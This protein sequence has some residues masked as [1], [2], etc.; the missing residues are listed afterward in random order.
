[1]SAASSSP[2][3]HDREQRLR[4]LEPHTSF[5]VQ[6]PAGSGKTELLTL[7][8]LALLPTVAEPEQVLAITFTRK[9][10]AE[11]RA[12]I[13]AA[14]EAA[15]RLPAQTK[16]EQPEDEHQRIVRQLA[17]AA[18]AHANAHDWQLLE[19]PQRL[20]IQ[21]IDSLALS[22]ARQMPLLS[23]LGGQLSPVDDAE[24]LYALAAQRTLARLGS[25][26]DP[27]LAASLASMLELRDT[28]L[29]DCEA[30]IAGM[31][32]RREQWL[33][34]LPG[35][36]QRN[37]AW[38]EL[39]AELE[40]PFRRENEAV[41]AL[42]Q[43]RF[44]QSSQLLPELLELGRIACENGIEE[45]SVLQAV[46]TAEDL[47]ETAHCHALCDLLLTGTN[48]WRKKID[49]SIGF[50][51]TT[52]RAEGARLKELIQSL[53]EDHA[54]LALLCRAR[55]LPPPA[56]TDQEWSL[57]RSI[58]TLLR[59]AIAELRVVFAEQGVIDFAEAGIAAHAALRDPGVLMRHEDRIQHV[60]VDEFQDTSRPHLALL[61]KLLQDW[62]PSDGRTCFFVGDPMQSIYLFRDA[63]ASL[64][65]QMRSDAGVELGGNRHAVASL[66]LATNFRS[67]S[68][69]VEPLNDV[70]LRVLTED[71]VDGVRYAPCHSSQAL[72]GKDEL[73]LHMQIDAKQQD[74][75][76]SQDPRDTEADALVRILQSHLPAV[77]QASRDGAKYRVAVLVR[78]RPHLLHIIGRL[79]REGIPF[80]GVKIDRLRDRPEILDLL[81]LLRALLHP[82]DRIAW[83][84]VL[85]AP[86]C[87]LTLPALYAICGDPD[88]TT[89]RASIPELL[90]EHS[91]RLDPTS[92]T[93]ALH[94]LTI[95]EHAAAAY[96]GGALANSPVA[97]A[98]WLE[99]TWHALGAPRYLDAEAL[100][101]A[102]VFFAALAEMPPSCLGTLDRSFNRRLDDLYA[103]PDPATSD[104]YGVQLMTIHGAK[105]LEFEVVLLPGLDRQGKREDPALF[106]WL[107]RKRADG[108]SDELLLAPIGR[109][110]GDTPALYDWVKRKTS[111]R[112]RQ[113]HK[114]LL[115]VA[116]SRAARELHLFATVKQNDDGT[117]NKAAEGTLLAAGWA[118]LEPR[119]AAALPSLA[120]ATP[121]AL[122]VM[123]SRPA[124]FASPTAGIL[125]ALAASAPAQVLHRLPASWFAD[126]PPAALRGPSATTRALRSPQ[127]HHARIRGT[128]LH[129]LLERIAARGADDFALAIDDPLWERPV[130]ALLRQH[131]LPAPAAESLR[132]TILAALRNSMR[133]DEGR[134]LLTAR[135]PAQGKAS[136]AETSGIESSWTE[137]SWTNVAAHRL[138][139]HRPDRIFLGGASP[140][141]PGTDYL[142]IIDYKTAATAADEDREA[143]LAASRE[144]YRE[145]LDRY[146]RLFREMGAS[147]GER[148]RPHRLALYH[149]ML[150]YLDWW[151]A[152]G[153]SD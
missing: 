78:A 152:S 7:R 117:L 41:L 128:V 153:S 103:Q 99:R 95:L 134:W 147:D 5:L 142:W 33:L 89:L 72:S 132:N 46:R 106:Q 86:W 149:P 35:I 75:R 129:A 92:R 51:A 34:L 100:A 145:Q 29:A 12:R 54:L 60:L 116:C 62:Q 6:A 88:D 14:L 77:E 137:T 38:Q 8:Y 32:E 80:R 131:A 107:V 11:M 58:F 143:F 21:T 115:Y 1:M 98:L 55:G 24:P 44:A 23:Q 82:A 91:E 10:T 138:Q 141:A 150:P 53:A 110:R 111:Q 9:A 121:G 140:D 61:R 28:S 101:N 65:D 94:L 118:G 126:A 40:A 133:H 16:P 97:L 22:I 79:R 70:F 135:N 120:T 148:A 130:T 63:E 31:L 45:L 125:P 93:R 27:E 39:R 85:R 119:I 76:T 43:K 2:M 136:G 108:S 30:L 19:Q 13:L 151:S 83:L 15:S 105:G 144:Q 113:E 96:A 67:T 18:L 42:L 69:I 20:N 102:D 3:V 87:G 123:P 114:R 25:A 146:S 71:T 90:R 37:P 52:H 127:D 17:V 74:P 36:T 48:T 112:L 109:K 47:K 64:F 81:S 104:R 49:K 84:A 122:V 26:D 68:A 124:S 139:R 4:S 59:R 50:P 73:H 56:Y 57:V 66:E